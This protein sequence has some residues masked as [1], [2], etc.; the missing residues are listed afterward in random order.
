MA[1][2]KLGGLRAL[3]SVP[4]MALTA[5]ASPKTQSDIMES[6]G[7]RKP[8]VVSGPLNRPNIFLSAGP[9]SG[10]CVSECMTYYGYC[11]I[12]YCIL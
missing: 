6:L 9:M 12:L 8:V 1:F 2:K 5:T 4:F 11:L 10:L 3:T 7:L